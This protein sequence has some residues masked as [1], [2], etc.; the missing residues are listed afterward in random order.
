MAETQL[1]FAFRAQGER[2]A[3][4]QGRAARFLWVLD[5]KTPG[6]ADF[7]SNRQCISVGNVDANDRAALILWL[8]QVVTGY[9]NYHAV[10]TNSS[11]LTAFLFHVTNLWR[12]TLWLMD[13]PN[14]WRLKLYA[15]AELRD[16]AEF[17]HW[18]RQLQAHLFAGILLRQSTSRC[19][20]PLLWTS[21]S[22]FSS[23]DR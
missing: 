7:R 18:T 14:R 23:D 16:L 5:D 4:A 13:Y 22:F 2:L 20:V 8:Q 10:P 1:V 17:Y 12:R 19:A 15:H 11:T 3:A 21:N 9:F 6:C